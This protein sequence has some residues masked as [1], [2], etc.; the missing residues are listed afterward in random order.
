MF[1]A[2]LRDD[3]LGLSDNRLRRRPNV[4][5]IAEEYLKR[6]GMHVEDLFH[7]LLAVLHDPAYR[8]A[9][10]DAIRM[11]WP[12]IPI[13][14]WPDGKADGAADALRRSAEKGRKIASLLDPSKR[15]AGV[16]ETP[17]QSGI[18]NI[19]VP[20]TIYSRNM[21]GDD[22]LL[23]AGWGRGR[24]G[25]DRPVMPGK[26]RIEQRKYTRRE[27]QDLGPS[28]SVLGGETNDVY[29]ND[30]AYWRNVP[31]AVWNYKLGGYQVLKKWLSYREHKVLGR[32]LK[33]DEVGYFAEAARRIAGIL[34]LIGG[35]TLNE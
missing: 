21:T 18:F 30:T 28:I 24:Y 6:L 9:N 10:A 12:R 7:H 19:A 3:G 16:I 11:G 14:D 20:S 31:A 4:S 27:R 33:P 32:A 26:G 23:A 15:V 29:L 35:T 34:M 1:P 17:L 5:A 13:P 22:Y 2:Y 8:E 25:S